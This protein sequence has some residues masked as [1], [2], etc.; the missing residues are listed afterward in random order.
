[1]TRNQPTWTGEKP[2]LLAGW[3][4]RVLMYLHAGNRGSSISRPARRNANTEYPGSLFDQA[5]W[6][7]PVTFGTRA[8]RYYY[9]LHFEAVEGHL[10]RV[11][12][13]QGRADWSTVRSQ[14]RKGWGDAQ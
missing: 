4:G 9:G 14:V 7:D 11:W 8:H 1:M 2:G 10:R 6:L 13:A 12:T 3:V 5:A